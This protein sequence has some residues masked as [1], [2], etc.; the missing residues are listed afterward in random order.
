MM[1]GLQSITLCGFVK[2]TKVKMYMLTA[3]ILF[4]C[5]IG[6]FALNNVE[7]DMWT[8]FWF[9]VLGFVMRSLGFPIVP[10]ILGA[11]LGSI[12]ETSLAQS[13]A[14]TDDLSPFFTRP[15]SLFFILLGMMSI[16]FPIY[17]KRRGTA[18]W[19]RYFVP[20]FA[21]ILSVPVFMMGGYVRP[22][23]AVIMIVFALVLLIKNLRGRP[24]ETVL[25]RGS[26]DDV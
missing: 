26:G 5:S 25:V 2:I 10:I 15:W 7:F 13:L 20:V 3:V 4:Y 16:F 23:L 21:V 17:Q 14:I 18:T 11:V 19:T 22:V 8:L 12:A 9:G 24:D 1:L 6:V